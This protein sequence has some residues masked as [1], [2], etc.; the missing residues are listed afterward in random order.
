MKILITG[1]KGFV[2]KNLTEALKNIKDGKNRTRP[3][4]S[5][6]ELYL[7]DTDSAP[8]S[9]AAYC[10]DCDF[11][12]HFAG[13]NRP[14][15]TSE[16]FVDNVGFTEHLLTLLQVRGNT[17]PVMFASS[18][19]ASLEGRFAGSA[20]GE[21]KIAA[22][23]LLFAHAKATGARA[24]VFRLPNLF[25]KWSRP[26][27][28]SVIA[29]FCY[30]IARGIPITVND[31]DV[32]L[33]LLYIDDL[34]AT[35]FDAL[36]GRVTR[37]D[38]DGLPAI[39]S[40]EGAYC[41]APGAHTA[42][43]GNI[44]EMLRGFARLPETLCVPE[45]TEGSLQKQLYS[46]YL[47]FL[48]PEQAAF[49]LTVR[50]DARGSFTELLKTVS[51]GQFSVN[52]SNPGI[53]KGQHW[54]DSKWELFIVVSGEALIRQRAVGADE[55]FEH[56]VSGSAPTAVRMLP[57]YTHSIINLSPTENLITLMWANEPFDPARPDT[58]S[59]PV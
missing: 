49:P 16:F 18:I 54:H 48:P 39:P 3:G 43:L 30:R 28:N 37:C 47:S 45:L 19:Q 21:S 13:V 10:A 52:V 15:D 26:D 57:G 50:A 2:G 31:P 56:R 46:T 6:E 17:C 27:Y 25:G 20:Y 23:R 12:F 55:V 40:A 5:V 33:D 59:E 35:L 4:L 38:W 41:F 22:E 7:Y 14:R 24:L 42:R 51:G 53:T 34:I 29:T 11:V 58:F 1:A 8:E 32:M 36:E 44:A 9:L